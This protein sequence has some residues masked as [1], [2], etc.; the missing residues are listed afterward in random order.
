MGRRIYEFIN[1]M[2]TIF[3][4]CIS[5]SLLVFKKSNVLVL[6]ERVEPRKYTIKTLNEMR[7]QFYCA[8]A[9]ISTFSTSFDTNQESVKKELHVR[10][11]F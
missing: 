2:L 1:I 7:F 9:V 8:Q 4:Q 3:N 11:Q 10:G 6:S 5:F